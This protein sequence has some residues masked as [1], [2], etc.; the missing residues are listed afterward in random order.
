MLWPQ[1]LLGLFLV[2]LGYGMRYVRWRM[3][4]DALN[5]HPP[6]A[7][8]ALIWISSYAFTV[9]PGKS[10]E[11][12]R[13]LLLKKEFAYPISK[14]LMALLVE[15]ISDVISVLVLLIINIPLLIGWKVSYIVPVTLLIV[16]G[17]LF[18]LFLQ[19]QVFI[20]RLFRWIDLILPRK[21]TTAG[22]HSV[23]ALKELLKFKLLFL[24][25][26]IGTI[27]WS[28]EGV[29][30]WLLLKGLGTT[31]ISIGGATVAH[32]SAGL[33]GALTMIPGGL[34]ST[35]AGTIGILGLQGLTVD[36]STPATLL[37]RLMTL[38][39]ATSLGVICLFCSDRR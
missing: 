8:D 17:S 1:V 13:A 38:W 6:I 35:E 11:A 14:S 23:G 37:I 26:V 32:T 15:R 9:T 29:S 5:Q 20:N 21:F 34:G 25:T 31:K 16:V 3:L 4:M 7:R 18:W 22:S 36:L 2:L 24:S 12:I 10:G 19:Q 27:S 39:F 33:F 28:L 30:L